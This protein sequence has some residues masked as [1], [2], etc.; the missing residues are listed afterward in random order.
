[1]SFRGCR[2][3][4]EVDPPVSTKLWLSAGTEGLGDAIN[5]DSTLGGI[6]KEAGEV[7]CEVGRDKAGMCAVGTIV[8]VVR[9]GVDNMLERFM[10]I[11]KKTMVKKTHLFILMSINTVTVF[12]CSTSTNHNTVT[13]HDGRD[14]FVYVN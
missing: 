7:A 14:L 11:E 13:S 6:S 4:K 3:A 8:E 10:I 9:W 1:M 12:K 5:G 2:W